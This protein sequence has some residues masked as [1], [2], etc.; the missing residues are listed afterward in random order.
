MSLDPLSS[1]STEMPLAK[2][3]SHYFIALAATVL[4]G[5]IFFKF[6]VLLLL[7]IPY[8]IFGVLLNRIVLRNLI[9]YHPIYDTLS[10]VS[11]T[12]LAAVMTWPVFYVVIFIKLAIVK[13]L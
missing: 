13:Y 9:R 1:K 8:F 5:L 12:K 2:A 7:I 11:N 10:N 3:W 6:D 4:A